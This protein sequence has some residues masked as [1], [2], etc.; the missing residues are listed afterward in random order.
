[1]FESRWRFHPTAF[2]LN[3]APLDTAYRECWAGLRA[4]G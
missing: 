1:M 2:A 3:E 4:P